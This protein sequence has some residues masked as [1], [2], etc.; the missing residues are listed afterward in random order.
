MS[1]TE[2]LFEVLGKYDKTLKGK[3]EGYRCIRL[4]RSYR[5]YYRIIHDRIVFVYV[6]RVDKHEY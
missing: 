4:N 2:P 3:L 5:A 6:E 1:L